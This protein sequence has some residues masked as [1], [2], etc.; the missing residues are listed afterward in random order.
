M[1]Y[2]ELD[3]RER[4]RLRRSWYLSLGT[5]RRDGRIVR[6]PVW[7]AEADGCFW[8]FTAAGAGKV[9]RLRNDPCCQI[10]HCD[11]WGGNLGP[12][13]EALGERVSN[14]DEER[15]GYRALRAKYGWQMWLTDLLS[16]VSGRYHRRALLKLRPADSERFAA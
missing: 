4:A 9:K 1:Q 15:R 14:P 2:S 5:R 12:L 13:V 16:R 7:F 10:A 6:T 8:V 11:A 3:E